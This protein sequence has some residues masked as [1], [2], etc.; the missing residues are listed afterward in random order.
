MKKKEQEYG[1]LTTIIMKT[2]I[3]C[4]KKLMV[5]NSLHFVNFL[6]FKFTF[7]LARERV[8]GWYSTGPK[9]KPNDLAI[10]EVFRNYTPSGHPV[11]VIVE[12]QPK[13]LGIPTKAYVTVEEVSEVKK[14]RLKCGVVSFF[15]IILK[16]TKIG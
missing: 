1:F 2:C 4:S 14:L 12:V 13:D 15:L 5:H 16:Q 3:T 11:Y 9:I 7:R 8:V 6:S 10:H